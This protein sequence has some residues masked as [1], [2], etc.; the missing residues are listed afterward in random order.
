M[1]FLDSLAK[2][3]FPDFDRTEFVQ[4]NLVSDAQPGHLAAAIQ[5]PNLINPWGSHFRRR[6][7]FG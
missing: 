4:S 5:D 3:R 2:F 7:R 6:A 1:K